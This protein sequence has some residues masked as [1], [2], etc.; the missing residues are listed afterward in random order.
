VVEE[1]LLEADQGDAA[2]DLAALD[3]ARYVGQP[4][5]LDAIGLVL[6]D[7]FATRP[8]QL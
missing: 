3:H 5:P 1:D 7:W 6:L 2:D 4:E 8:C